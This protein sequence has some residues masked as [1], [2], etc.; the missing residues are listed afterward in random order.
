MDIGAAIAICILIALGMV[1]FVYFICGYQ[2][3]CS[4]NDSI[5]R[6]TL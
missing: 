4:N 5:L 2:C 1:I 6:D 3:K